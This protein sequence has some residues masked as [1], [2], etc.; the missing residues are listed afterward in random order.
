VDRRLNGVDTRP[1]TDHV[2][3]ARATPIP[4]MLNVQYATSAGSNISE[5]IAA[6]VKEYTIWQNETIGRAF[7]PDKLM[8][9][10]YQAGAIRVIWGEGSNFNGGG[11]TYSTI[12]E[13][14][15]CSGTISL[16]VMNA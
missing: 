3:V 10:L 7:N 6:A 14:E 12:G 13:S 16:A 4:Y 2:T 15:H 11:V 8:A 1:L 9:M 5:A